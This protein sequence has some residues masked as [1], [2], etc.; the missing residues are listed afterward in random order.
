M[1]GFTFLMDH[2]S[3]MDPKRTRR[4][5]RR[6]F[7]AM[8]PHGLKPPAGATAADSRGQDQSSAK[9]QESGAVVAPAAHRPHMFEPLLTRSGAMHV[10]SGFNVYCWKSFGR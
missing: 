2:P 1:A 8:P 10:L 5:L 4:T 3:L 9:G 6:D 7:R